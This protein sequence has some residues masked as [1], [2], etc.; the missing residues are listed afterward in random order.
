LWNDRIRREIVT[1]GYPVQGSLEEY[2][3]VWTLEAMTTG[4]GQ[5]KSSFAPGLSAAMPKRPFASIAFLD[6]V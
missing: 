2:I 3:S 1:S 6:D 4:P 5:K